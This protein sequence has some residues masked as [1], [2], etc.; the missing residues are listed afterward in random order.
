MKVSVKITNMEKVRNIRLS[1]DT[2]T[3]NKVIV[4]ADSHN[5]VN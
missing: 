4:N 2:V 5:L 1:G 3:L